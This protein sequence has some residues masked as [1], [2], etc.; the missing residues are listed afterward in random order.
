MYVRARACANVQ[1]S[2]AERVK[3]GFNVN[4]LLMKTLKNLRYYNSTI[5]LTQ[6]HNQTRQEQEITQNPSCIYI[7]HTSVIEI[8]VGCSCSSWSLYARNVM[9]ALIFDRILIV[10]GRNE[11]HLLYI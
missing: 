1:Q 5:E 8:T 2:V 9:N 6:Q 3:T 4:Q 11:T 10:A 7:F